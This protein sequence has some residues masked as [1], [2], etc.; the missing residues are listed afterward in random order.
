MAGSFKRLEPLLD[1]VQKAPMDEAFKS[2]IS[3]L[4]TECL[5]RAIEERTLTK[6]TPE[7]ERAEH[8]RSRQGRIHADALFL[9]RAGQVRKRSGGHAQR[10]YA[11]L[12]GSIEV[13]KEMKRASQIQFAAEA[14]PELLHLA[15]RRASTCCSTRSGGWR[16]AIPKRRRNWRKRR[17][18]SRKKIRD[19]RSSFWRKSPPRIGIWRGRAPTLN[20]RC[21][22]RM[23]PR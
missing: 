9:R 12:V 4:V 14:A 18:T 20:E 3:L 21:R 8:R 5:V 16:R 2:N 23:N 13:G 22:R 11:D 17:W 15:G 7:A 19:A 10:V 1:D 6:K